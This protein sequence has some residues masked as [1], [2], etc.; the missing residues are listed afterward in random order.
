[1]HAMYVQKM[2]ATVELYSLDRHIQLYMS[3][4]RDPV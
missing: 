2:R 1:M 4:D 3:F